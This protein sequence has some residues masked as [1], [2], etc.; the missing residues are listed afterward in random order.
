MFE[1]RVDDSVGFSIRRVVRSIGHADPILVTEDTVDGNRVVQGFPTLGR[2]FRA[3]GDQQRARGHQGMQL[4]QVEVDRSQFRIE[5]MGR[6]VRGDQ[7]SIAPGPGMVTEVPGF[8]VIDT[9]TGVIENDS[10]I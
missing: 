5:S 6:V 9:G 7:A 10:R 8:P 4:M 3:A 1:E 2:I